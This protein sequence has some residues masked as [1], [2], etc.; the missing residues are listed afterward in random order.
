M[1][2]TIEDIAQHL[3]LAVSTVSKALNGYSDVSQKTKDLVREAARELNYHPSAAA[4][5]LR[6]QRTDKIGLLF[7]FPVT[8]ISEWASRLIT[9][10][11]TA[12]EQEGHNLILYPLQENQLDQLT[13][14][15]RTREVDGLLLMPGEQLEQSVAFLEQEQVPFAVLGQRV[16]RPNVSFVAADNFKAAVDITNHLI[17]L[18]HKRIAYLSRAVLGKTSLDRMTGY[19]QALLEADLPFDE[20]LIVPTAPE[21]GSNQQAMHKLLDLTD[22]PTAVFAIHDLV[23]MDALE[24]ALERGL[25]VPHDVAIVG[26][27]NWRLSLTTTPPLTT[28]H[29]PL[30]EMGRRATEILLAHVGDNT[31]PPVRVELPVR[32]VVRQSTAE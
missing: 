11:V 4:R 2:V 9:G 7:S 6:R 27:D 16:D 19:K 26:F 30:F 29:P 12:A 18:G 31:L 22:P 32:L 23:A 20:R 25:R 15:C 3:N 10:A 5:N 8:M 24:V 1:A 21:P 13:R 14:I 28:G 17:A